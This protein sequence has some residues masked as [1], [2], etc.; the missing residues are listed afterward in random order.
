M[1]I[2]KLLGIVLLAGGTLV[3]IYRGF[4]YTSEKHTAHLGPID[5]QVKEKKRL[6]IPIWAGVVA[7]VAGAAFLVLPQR[8]G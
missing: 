3:L 5:F 8:K 1:N 6:D 4:T 2:R 7:I